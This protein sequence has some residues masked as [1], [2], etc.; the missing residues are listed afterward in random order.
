MEAAAARYLNA[1]AEKAR[2]EPLIELRNL[3]QDNLAAQL[4]YDSSSKSEGEN[5]W[6]H[7]DQDFMQSWRLRRASH[8]RQ[9]PMLEHQANAILAASSQGSCATTSVVSDDGV[10]ASDIDHEW[11]QEFI[12]MMEERNTP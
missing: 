2:A 3:W 9:R 4:A 1:P 12:L 6:I 5:P 10:A 7:G 11:E 8:G